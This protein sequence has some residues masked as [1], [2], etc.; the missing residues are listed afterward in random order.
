MPLAQPRLLSAHSSLIHMTGMAPTGSNRMPG[1]SLCPH[2]APRPAEC[3][4][5]ELGRRHVLG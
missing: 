5:T 1:L 4:F 2:Q 3:A